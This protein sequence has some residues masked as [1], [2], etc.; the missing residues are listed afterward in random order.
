MIEI[1]ITAL[2]AAVLLGW[3]CEI[4]LHYKSAQQCRHKTRLAYHSR[5]LYQCADC[6]IEIAMDDQSA[7]IKHQ[8]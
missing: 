7:Q 8:R 5:K 1:L 3:M 6:G 4:I 2:L